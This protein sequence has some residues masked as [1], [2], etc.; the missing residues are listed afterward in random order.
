M[1]K[2]PANDTTLQSTKQMLDELDALMEQMLSMPVHDAEEA[3]RF[4]KDI[5][6]PQALTATLTLLESPAPLNGPRTPAI[7]PP[8]NPPHAAMSSALAPLTNDAVPVSML[9]K[10]DPMLAAIPESDAAPTTRWCYLPLLWINQLFDGWTF[11]LGEWGA[12]LRTQ[13]S[14]TLLGIMGIALLVL[15]AGWFVKDWLGWNW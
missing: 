11:M 2:M 6:K 15:A 1:A 10:V 13:V 3:P 8:L 7:H 4:P 5:V 9:A 12:M 14:R